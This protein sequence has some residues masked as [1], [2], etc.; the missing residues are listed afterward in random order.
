[1]TESTKDSAEDA[2][3][4]ARNADGSYAAMIP[5]LQRTEAEVAATEEEDEGVARLGEFLKDRRGSTET[6]KC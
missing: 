1:M 5:E 4:L 3:I 2:E 6:G